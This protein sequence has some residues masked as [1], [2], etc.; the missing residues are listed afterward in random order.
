M[1]ALPNCWVSVS[2]LTGSGVAVTTAVGVGVFV[3]SIV[4]VEVNAS[5]G[6]SV[7]TALSV[8]MEVVCWPLDAGGLTLS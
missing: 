4:G 3:A 8:D 2:K 6:S 5:V 1:Q 7:G